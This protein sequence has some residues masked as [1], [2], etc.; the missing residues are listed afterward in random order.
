MRLILVTTFFVRYT[1]DGK[2]GYLIP[3]GEGNFISA[4][5]KLIE[6]SEANEE[7]L[8]LGYIPESY[9]E[10]LEKAYPGQFEF[11]ED[12]IQPNT[13]IWLKR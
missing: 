9:V 12:R 11:T 7:Y 8:H 5:D 1:D 13:Y 10:V 2:K 4:M 3:A 6:Y